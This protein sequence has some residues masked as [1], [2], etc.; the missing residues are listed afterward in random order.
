MPDEPAAQ[1]QHVPRV[2]HYSNEKRFSRLLPANHEN[3]HDDVVG[4]IVPRLFSDIYRSR[5]TTIR[6]P[7]AKAIEPVGDN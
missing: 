1:H 4:Q 2:T 5:L 6:F 3:P 7:V